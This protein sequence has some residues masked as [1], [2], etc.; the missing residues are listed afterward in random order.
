MGVNKSVPKPPAFTS[1][2]L[3]LD[4]FLITEIIGKNIFIKVK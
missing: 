3:T 2:S 1:S 4:V